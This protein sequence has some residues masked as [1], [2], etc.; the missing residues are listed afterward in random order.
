MITALPSDP[1]SHEMVTIPSGTVPITTLPISPSRRAQRPRSGPEGSSRRD[2]T[3]QRTHPLINDPAAA[4]DEPAIYVHINEP[5]SGLL[6]DMNLT[7]R[8]ESLRRLT[9]DKNYTTGYDN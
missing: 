7:V 2:C 6:L 5:P 8:P 4:I 3:H 9:A 1:T